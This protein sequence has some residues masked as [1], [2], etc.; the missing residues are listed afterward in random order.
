[1]VN[2]ALPVILSAAVVPPHRPDEEAGPGSN[3]MDESVVLKSSEDLVG[4]PGVA[5]RRFEHP[6]YGGSPMGASE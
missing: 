4:L 2:F 6:P 3:A 1:M 5:A